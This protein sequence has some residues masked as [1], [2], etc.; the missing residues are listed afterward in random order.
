MSKKGY[1]EICLTTEDG[2][3]HLRCHGWLKRSDHLVKSEQIF[4]K[5]SQDFGMFI[6]IIPSNELWGINERKGDLF[7]SFEVMNKEEERWDS[8]KKIRNKDFIEDISQFM[9]SFV[10]EEKIDIDQF[11]H[12]ANETT[13]KFF[14]T[15]NDFRAD[16]VLN[17]NMRV[18]EKIKDLDYLIN[19]FEALERYEDCGVL[20][21]V[22]N[23][24]IA[25]EEF[26][27][28]NNING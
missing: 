16:Y 5:D 13:L 20:L 26:A 21:K 28:K 19:Y 11:I 8:Y 12:K 24:I 15:N 27:T 1:I 17:E 4:G 23:K 7:N 2:I 9:F 18:K 22:K 25:N 3:Q 14:K 6:I 10:P